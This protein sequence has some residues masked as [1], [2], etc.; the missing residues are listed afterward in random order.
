VPLPAA[1]L[2]GVTV[3]MILCAVIVAAHRVRGT[4]PA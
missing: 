2:V 1:A 3:A 4:N